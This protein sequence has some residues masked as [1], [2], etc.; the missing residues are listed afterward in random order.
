MNTT[1]VKTH[2]AKTVTKPLPAFVERGLPGPFPRA[3][4]GSCRQLASAE[5]NLHRQWHSAGLASGSAAC[6]SVGNRLASAGV[7]GKLFHDLRRT[8]VRNMVRAGVPEQVAMAISGHKTRS[9][10]DRHNIVTERDRTMRLPGSTLTCAIRPAATPS[11]PQE[12]NYSNLRSHG[13]QRKTPAK[14]PHL[15]IREGS[16]RVFV[17]QGM[18]PNCGTALFAH[19]RRSANPLQ[20]ASMPSMKRCMCS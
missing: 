20:A 5:R 18:K 14:S 19:C 16:S 7:T 9:D 1:G 4:Q 13:S 11:N 3:T 10:F 6:M 15:S 8:T 2:T 12:R 17:F